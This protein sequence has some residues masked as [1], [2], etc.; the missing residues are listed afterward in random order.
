MFVCFWLIVALV[1][2][3]M[4]KN[5]RYA[6][7]RYLADRSRSILSVYLLFLGVFAYLVLHLTFRVIDF[8]QTARE[9]DSIQPAPYV[10]SRDRGVPP[11]QKTLDNIIN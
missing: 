1:A 7:G 2:V 10:L 3:L 4:F 11:V 9:P 6:L 5:A 8:V